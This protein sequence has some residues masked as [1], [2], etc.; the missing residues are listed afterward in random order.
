MK[1]PNVIDLP[2]AVKTRS[3]IPLNSTHVT[4]MDFG[5]TNVSLALEVMPTDKIDMDI[6]TRVQLSPLVVPTMGEATLYSRAFFVPFRF[7]WPN[8]EPTS[9]GKQFN[10][11]GIALNGNVP[12]LTEYRL[13]SALFGGIDTDTL[14]DSAELWTVTQSD[15]GA[16]D[17]ELRVYTDSSTYSTFY[18]VATAKGCDFLQ[19]LR[20][21]GYSFLPYLG[22]SAPYVSDS[23][24]FSAL[25]LLA[26][27]KVFRDYYVN[28]NYSYAA[29]DALLSNDTSYAW[30]LTAANIF[31]L[32]S[33]VRYA[34]YEQ[35]IFTS[36]WAQPETIGLDSLHRNFDVNGSFV[37]PGG[38]SYTD[39]VYGAR[40]DGTPNRTVLQQSNSGLLSMYGLNLLKSVRNFVMRQS[41]AGGRFIDQ[42]L[43]K[44]GIK[45]S[46]NE[47]RRSTFLGS[48]RCGLNISRVD[49][50]AAGTDGVSQSA[51]GDFSG[52]GTMSGNGHVHFEN[53]NNDFGMLF[54]ISHIIPTTHYFQGVLPHVYHVNMQ[55]FFMP[56][57]ESCGNVPI[58][59]NVLFRDYKNCLS[60][61]QN[62]S[63]ND[64]TFGFS[65][66][67]YEYKV[68]FDRLS[69]D[70]VLP[71]R[72][73]ELESFHMFRTLSPIEPESGDQMGNRAELTS[74]FLQMNDDNISSYQKIFNDRTN[75]ANHFIVDFDF[76]INANRPCLSL[77][78]T[79]NAQ[80]RE[81]GND[82][83]DLVKM[84]PNGQYF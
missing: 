14:E 17:Y 1:I 81:H 37:S 36:A 10:D 80:L 58:P 44:W 33:F 28:P 68:P 66:Y 84:R 30:A 2:K 52:R 35:D 31:T 7:C 60:W 9:A 11:K 53:N 13:Q 21:L 63:Y 20:S 29:I 75:F 4:T 54:V 42:T 43:S 38:T 22:D 82:V 49:A 65:A 77:V 26:L 39:P 40:D 6:I 74:E 50:T 16:Y 3:N 46:E 57:F 51:L 78:S 72:N 8:W 41:A 69:G 61:E 25:P 56:D 73:T 67:G 55:D 12:I 24:Q 23:Q 45:L 18:L 62:E 79:I 48:T 15:P 19:I 59:E 71:S 70:F 76:L 27:A 34:W 5:R 47:A 64:S 83:G 32:L